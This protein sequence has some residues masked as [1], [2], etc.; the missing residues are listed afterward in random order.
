MNRS[1]RQQPTDEKFEHADVAVLGNRNRLTQQR[2]LGIAV[3]QGACEKN[4]SVFLLLAYVRDCCWQ[5]D[6][7]AD[8][9]TYPRLRSAGKCQGVA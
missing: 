4:S 1:R 7:G 6:G 8:G 3:Q 9:G 5:I 2:L